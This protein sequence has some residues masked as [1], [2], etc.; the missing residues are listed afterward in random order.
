MN[1]LKKGFYLLLLVG[2]IISCGNNDTAEI[3]DLEAEVGDLRE[4]GVVFWVDPA[5][6]THGLVCALS[7]SDYVSQVNSPTWWGCWGEDLPNVSNV[8][9]N[10][11][12]PSGLGAEIGDGESN[13][14]SILIDCPSHQAALGARSLGFEWFLPSAKELNEI[15]LNQSSLEVVTGFTA[16]S[17]YNWSSTEID[18]VNVWG[19]GDGILIKSYKD[20]GYAVRAIRAF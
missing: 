10:G 13:T 5:D 15:Y 17:G 16:L 12:V 6:K 1:Y 3:I 8:P 9:D 11:A 7:D 20:W 14:N 19:I 4:G 2:S 18:N